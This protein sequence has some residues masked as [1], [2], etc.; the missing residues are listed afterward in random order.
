M[1]EALYTLTCM[2][3]KASAVVTLHITGIY[4]V[5]L[6]KMRVGECM[7]SYSNCV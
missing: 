1:K 4:L 2:P 5:S 3:C 6:E 7:R